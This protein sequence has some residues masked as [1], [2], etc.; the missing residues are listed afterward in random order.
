M[1]F[2]VVGLVLTVRR[3][4]DAGWPL[5]LVV[6]FFAP[7]PINLIFFVVLS[8]IPTRKRPLYEPLGDVIDGPSM[9][10]PPQ[11]ALSLSLALHELATNAAKYGALSVEHGR[12]EV[13]W[14]RWQDGLWL[15]W[16][17]RGGP[18]VAPPTHRGFG[19]RLLESSQRDL[20]GAC[21]LDYAADGVRAEFIAAIGQPAG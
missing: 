8:M 6:L 14:E 18:P 21:R 2:V 7:M 15:T 1:P 20:G 17:E 10:I 9:E 11:H 16:R 3:L 5:W 4:R 19:S 13:R 12:I